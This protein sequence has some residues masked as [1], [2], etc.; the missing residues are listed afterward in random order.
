MTLHHAHVHAH[1]HVHVHD[2]DHVNGDC[3]RCE[4]LLDSYFLIGLKWLGPQA[5]PLPRYKPHPHRQHNAQ[6]CLDIIGF[7]L[8]ARGH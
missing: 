4:I 1:A 6:F 8:G 2:H 3:L 5:T 7:S